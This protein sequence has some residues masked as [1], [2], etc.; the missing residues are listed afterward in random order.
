M[1]EETPPGDDFLA[2]VARA[3]EAEAE[4]AA[5]GGVRVVV[6]RNGHRARPRRRRASSA[7]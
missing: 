4:R 6:L 1:T 2:D 3:W 7:C 5:T